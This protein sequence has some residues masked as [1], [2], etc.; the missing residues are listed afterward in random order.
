[1]ITRLK[2]KGFKNLVDIDVRFGPF[3]CIAGPNGVGKSNLFDA[4]HF[5]SLLS[6]MPLID[7]AISLRDESGKTGDIGSLFHS[8]KK[9]SEAR[10]DFEVEM[11]VPEKGTDDYG[12]PV[13]A[14]WTF[15]RYKLSL[16]QRHPA[17]SISMMALEVLFEELIR[18]PKAEA[19]DALLFSSSKDWLDSVIKGSQS[20]NPKY[21][22]TDEENGV[23]RVFLRQDAGADPDKEKHKS[24]K[25]SPVPTSNL[26]RTVLSSINS[27]ERPTVL[28]AKREMQSWR[29]LRLEPSALRRPDRFSEVMSSQT[30]T[31]APDGGHLPATLYRLYQGERATEA[32]S[33]IRNRLIKLLDDVVNIEVDEDQTR[34]QLSLEARWRDGTTLPARS[35]SEGTLRFLALAVLEQDPE[36]RGVICLEEPENGIHPGRI[37]DMIDLL[38]D[39][40]MDAQY[41]VG[42]DNPLRQVIIN[43]H[44][45]SVVKLIGDDS[46]LVAELKEATQKEYRYKEVV[47][48]CVSKTW[49]SDIKGA[50]IVSKGKLLAYLASEAYD[51]EEESLNSPVLEKSE[52][53]YRPRRMKFRR[54]LL[55]LD[56]FEEPIGAS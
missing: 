10:I 33:R 28:M 56:M 46:L 36:V 32:R 45:P 39:I 52:A 53:P 6:E 16:G 27:A 15:L 31:I 4:I 3:T 38:N 21:L 35:L 24:G 37:K 7:A 51:E 23:R 25:P 47:F 13:F 42:D 41:P 54:D 19:T 49:R 50:S 30:V 1:M 17:N 8:A 55:T 20:H 18:I 5:L 48:S 44:S 34:Q 40:V 14:A 2:V 29:Q 43:T 9:T 22:Y 12:Q 11:I 26:P